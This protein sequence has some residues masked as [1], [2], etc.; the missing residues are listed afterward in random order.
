[1]PPSPQVD[2]DEEPELEPDEE[3]EED[4]EL[5]PEEEPEED[6]EDEPELDPELPPLEEPDPEPDPFQPPSSGLETVPGEF[7][8]AAKAAAAKR[9]AYAGRAPRNP[10]AT[11]QQPPF[12]RNPN[13]KQAEALA[14][15]ELHSSREFQG[16]ERDVGAI[17]TMRPV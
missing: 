7:E 14:R 2:P 12:V 9:A 4:P 5:D 11:M 6:P 15:P 1:M 8:H 16:L 17:Q 13:R 10:R 3:P